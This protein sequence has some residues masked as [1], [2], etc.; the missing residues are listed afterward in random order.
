MNKADLKDRR[1]AKHIVFHTRKS[2]IGQYCDISAKG[3][4]NV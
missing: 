3:G 2:N 1:V 4:Y